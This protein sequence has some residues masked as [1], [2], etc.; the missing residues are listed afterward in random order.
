MEITVIS[1]DNDEKVDAI[2]V[3]NKTFA[4]LTTVTALLFPTSLFC[5]T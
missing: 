4:K 5:S 1:N 2:F 3:N